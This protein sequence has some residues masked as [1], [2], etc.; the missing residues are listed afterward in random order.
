MTVD[1]RETNIRNDQVLILTLMIVDTEE[2][3]LT[4]ELD[5]FQRQL[6]T[7]K[8]LRQRR[9]EE[10]MRRVT[11]RL[12]KTRRK[13]HRSRKNPNHLVPE[14]EKE[15]QR[16]SLKRKSQKKRN[17]KVTGLKIESDISQREYRKESIRSSNW[18]LF[19][20]SVALPQVISRRRKAVLCR[21]NN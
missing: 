15:K 1:A 20:A 9:R 7:R 3:N 16:T 19:R 11:L 18:S 12:N 8:N 10:K 17:P 6:V 13:T 4:V 5:R 21:P 2:G 14:I